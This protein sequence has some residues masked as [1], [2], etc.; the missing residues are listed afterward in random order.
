[1]API[2]TP[3]P[4]LLDGQGNLY[5]TTRTGASGAVGLCLSRLQPG[6]NRSSTP[7]T[8]GVSAYPNSSLSFDATGNLYGTTAGGTEF[9]L[10]TSVIDLCSSLSGRALRGD[11][12]KTR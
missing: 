8:A 3:G 2:L 7:S 9:R 11:Y 4:V 12:A 5:G 6:W 10:R 1:M